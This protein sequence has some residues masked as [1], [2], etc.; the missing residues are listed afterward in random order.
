LNSLESP[1]AA[2]TSTTPDLVRM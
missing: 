2:R 1:V